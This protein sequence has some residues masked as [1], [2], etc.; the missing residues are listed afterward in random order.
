MKVTIV[1]GGNL[2]TLMAA[3]FAHRGH[4]V[5]IRTSKPEKFSK[6]LEAYERRDK[7]NDQRC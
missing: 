6:E 2:G 1:G 4:E 3:T 5:T 7:H